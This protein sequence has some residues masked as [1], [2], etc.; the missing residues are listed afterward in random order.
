MRRSVV[1]VVYG[2]EKEKSTKKVDGTLKL[3]G[4]GYIMDYD[5]G[6][7]MDY[8]VRRTRPGAFNPEA[9]PLRPSVCC[10]LYIFLLI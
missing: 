6:A 5:S 8:A 9:E 7:R 10:R 3:T 4:D 1:R 2:T